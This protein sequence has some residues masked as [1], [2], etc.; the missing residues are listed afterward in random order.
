MSSTRVPG[1]V[2][3]RSPSGRAWRPG[4]GGGTAAKKKAP[5][6]NLSPAALRTH[7]ELIRS[8]SQLKTFVPTHD[9]LPA[10]RS[11][12][13]AASRSRRLQ[14][15]IGNGLKSKGWSDSWR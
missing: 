13:K 7:V 3:V 1:S 14:A 8:S 5:K 12:S 10:L 15:A 2:P 6:M 4:M 9:L 11:L